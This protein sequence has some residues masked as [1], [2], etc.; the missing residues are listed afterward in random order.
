MLAAAKDEKVSIE[1]RTAA[2]RA[3]AD[4]R[5]EAAGGVLGSFADSPRSLQVRAAAVK[6]LCVLNIESAAAHAANLFSHTGRPGLNSASMLE[7]FLDRKDGGEVLAAALESSKMTPD[8]SR[9]LLQSLYETGRSDKALVAVLRK[10]ADVSGSELPYS[11]SYIKRLVADATAMGNAQRGAA[12]TESCVACHRIEK[13]GGVIGPDLTSIG[14]TLSAERIV[15]EVLWPTRQVKEDYTM[16]QVTT[17]DGEVHQ[18]YERRTKQSETSGDV[19]MRQLATDSLMT[20]R[21][22]RIESRQVLASAMPTGLTADLN[23]HQLLDLIRYLT[24]LGTRPS[25][26]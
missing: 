2:F 17:T 23:Q 7:A 13:I 4:M 1:V 11:E 24:T 20:L 10:A 26:K 9:A 25:S 8:S 6:A 5:L 18:G 19:V 16:L 14:T 3:M 21:K 12:L 22:D 15:E